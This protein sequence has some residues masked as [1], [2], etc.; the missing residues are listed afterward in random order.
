M[1]K[2]DALDAPSQQANALTSLS[3][4]RAFVTVAEARSFSHAAEAL[5]ISQPTVSQRIQSLENL[6]G[7]KLLDRRGKVRLTECGKEIFNHARLL[8]SRANELVV[9]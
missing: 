7:L 1:P 4:V 6:Y 9:R 8:I 3:D 2:R 5:G